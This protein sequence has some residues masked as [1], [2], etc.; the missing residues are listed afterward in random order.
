MRTD[1]RMRPWAM[2]VSAAIVAALIGGGIQSAQAEEAEGTDSITVDAMSAM[3]GVYQTEDGQPIEVETEAGDIAERTITG[4]TA[5]GEPVQI[6]IQSS[7]LSDEDMQRLQEDADSGADEAPSGYSEVEPGPQEETLEAAPLDLDP[8]NWTTVSVVATTSSTASF[9]WPDNAGF[10]AIVD[11]A[12][13]GSSRGGELVLTDLNPGQEYSVELL[14]TSGAARTADGLEQT[15]SRLMSVTTFTGSEARD[16]DR[17]ISPL[18][19]QPYYN[20]FVHKTF[21]PDARVGGAQCN[22]VNFAY[23]FGGDNRSWVMPG[24]DEPWGPANYRTLMFVNI[25]WDNPAP[26][27]VLTVKN[28]GPTRVLKNGVVERTLYANMDNMKFEEPSAGASY[29]QIYLRH[30]AGNPG[31]QFFDVAYGGKISYGEWVQFY[32]SGTI[33]ANGYRLP[34][35]AHELYGAFTNATGNNVWRVIS[36]RANQ[37]F[38]CLLGNAFCPLDFYEMSAVY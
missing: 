6:I 34:A 37:G 22:W 35:P 25:N 21:I 19:Y 30:N 3:D 24:I 14:A 9:A 8:K 32:R 28:V 17:L 13:E 27:D 7:G 33:T 26:Y 18:T 4:R 5:S 23:E 20:Q 36:R 12:F 15:S 16:E 2:G 31:C 11:G 29:A 1:R 10:D 38:Q